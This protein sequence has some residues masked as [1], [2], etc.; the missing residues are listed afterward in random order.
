MK[1]SKNKIIDGS[2]LDENVRNNSV[3]DRSNSKVYKSALG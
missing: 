1:R 2:Y 3:K